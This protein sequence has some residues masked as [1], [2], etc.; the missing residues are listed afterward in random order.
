[1]ANNP[2]LL[3]GKSGE[4]GTG[5]DMLQKKIC[6]LGAFA[7]GK[8]SL[9]SRFVHSMFSDRYLTT[10]GV[11]IDKKLV[12][13]ANGDV[14]LLIW[15]LH[16]EDDLQE[17][18]PSYLR[19]M[20]G[21]LLVADASRPGTLPTAFDLHARAQQAVGEVP[22]LMLLNK[23]DLLPLSEVAAMQGSLA[24]PLPCLAT[25]ARDGTQVEAA[26]YQLAA[27]IVGRSRP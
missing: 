17:V 4:P 7:V 1:M 21:Y 20:D 3:R 23:S 16:G 25:S 8:T 14:M 13:V 9:V 2:P 27:Q 15:D 19:G 6:M 11:K 24:V 22:C 26:F 5:V 18:R 12:S 10:V